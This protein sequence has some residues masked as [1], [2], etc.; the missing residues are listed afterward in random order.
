MFILFLT[1]YDILQHLVTGNRKIWWSATTGVLCTV[2]CI[3][4][5]WSCNFLRL[6]K[7]WL[8]RKT[9]SC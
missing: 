1:L 9:S 2:Y 3:Y 7:I 5:N 8:Q 4:L 6:H